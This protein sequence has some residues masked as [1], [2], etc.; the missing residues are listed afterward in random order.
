LNI[1]DY[2]DITTYKFSGNEKFNDIDFNLTILSQFFNEDGISNILNLLRSYTREENDDIKKKILSDLDS[3]LKKAYD[4]IKLSDKTTIVEENKSTITIIQ[5]DPDNVVDNSKNIEFMEELNKELDTSSVPNYKPNVPISK[6][7]KILLLKLNKMSDLIHTK[8]FTLF[9]S[10]ADKFD[11]SYLLN[12]IE[13]T[14]G[15]VDTTISKKNIY[16]DSLISFSTQNLIE[17]YKN[18]LININTKYDE[19]IQKTKLKI[20]ETITAF[21][22]F[23]IPEQRSSSG[24]DK[25]PVSLVDQALAKDK[26]LKKIKDKISVHQQSMDLLIKNYAVPKKKS[27]LDFMDIFSKPDKTKID[28]LRA[29]IDKLKSDEQKMIF[30]IG[31]Q[32]EQSFKDKIQKKNGTHVRNIVKNIIINVQKKINNIVNNITSKNPKGGKKL[33]KTIKHISKR[34]YKKTKKHYKKINRYYSNT[35]KYKKKKNKKTKKYK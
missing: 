6:S 23:K 35:K 11:H 3:F 32:V 30:Q 33:N 10:I 31:E 22:N 18:M 16:D 25:S 34:H 26:N 29:K 12:K 17:P 15:S 28:K 2:I 13:T 21:T 14:L 8:L 27:I 24:R 7:S 9:D 5:G 20:D 1:I 19:L 4:I